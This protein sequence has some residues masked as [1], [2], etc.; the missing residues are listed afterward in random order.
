[1]HYDPRCFT[2]EEGRELLDRFVAEIRR[3]IADGAE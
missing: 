1:V 2:P 3:A